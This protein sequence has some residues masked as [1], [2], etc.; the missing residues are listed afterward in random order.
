MP[1]L[2]LH[3]EDDDD[4]DAIAGLVGQ[5]VGGRVE[6]SWPLLNATLLHP[7][8]PDDEHVGSF[9]VAAAPDMPYAAPRAIA[10]ANSGLVLFGD[11]GFLLRNYAEFSVLELG[12]FEPPHCHA[13]LGRVE[14]SLGEPT[15]LMRYVFGQPVYRN[16]YVEWDAMATLRLYGTDRD[17]VERHVLQALLTFEEHLHKNLDFHSLEPFEASDNATDDPILEPV[18][19]SPYL[20]ILDIEPLRLFHKGILA[21]DPEYAFLQFYRVL[22]YYSV[23]QH[24]DEIARQRWDRAVSNIEYVRA[25]LAT[26]ARDERAL[27]AQLVN[28]TC[29]VSTLQTATRAG[30]IDRSDKGTLAVRLYEFRNTLVHAKYD[31]RASLHTEPLLEPTETTSRWVDVVKLLACGAIQACGT[32]DR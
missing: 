23:L 26:I 22:E 2:P 18:V 4:D 25:T 11:Y 13:K 17:A 20:L 21:T 15:P 16:D 10:S 12:M 19:E 8:V 3:F 28:K 7:E 32:P 24:A 14:A 5:S 30:L 1:I 6:V 9:S 31:L 27:L 29:A